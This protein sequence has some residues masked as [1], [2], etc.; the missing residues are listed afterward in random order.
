MVKINFEL[1]NNTSQY[2]ANCKSVKLLCEQQIF[3]F[4]FSVLFRY[5]TY[6]MNFYFITYFL[7]YNGHINY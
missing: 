1:Y 7:K 2:L 5:Y 4:E 3:A 6:A